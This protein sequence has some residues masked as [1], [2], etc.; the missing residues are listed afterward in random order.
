VGLVL[1]I[2]CANV[3]S[4]LLARA[5]SRQREIAIRLAI[6]ARRGR[7]IRQLLV[8]SALLS[9]V[10][11]AGGLVLAVFSGRV[12]LDML[13]TGAFHVDFDLTPNGHV[14]AFTTGVA[15]FTALL[16][17][18]AP[19]LQSTALN[20][21]ASLK[22]DARTATGISRWL[23]SLV[24]LQVALSLVLLIGAALFVGTLR[25][26]RNL[27]PG[28]RT[29]G[30]LLT[31]LDVPP[32]TPSV[33]L[34]EIRRVPGVASASFST[35]TP[36]SGARWSEPA[37]PAG[38]A[39]PDRD[40]ALFVGADPQFF[41]TLKIPLV[42][43]RAFVDR[44]AAGGPF[45]AIVNERYVQR[46]FAGK[47]PLG[48]HL[49]AR[50]NQVPRD[51]EIVGVARDTNAIGLRGAA[52][53]V[54][55]IPYV[56]VPRNRFATLTVRASG[57]LGDVAAAMRRILQPA[58]PNTPLQVRPLSAQVQATML[59]E[60]L[61]A[62]LAGTLGVLALVL[63]SVGIYGLLAYAVARRT[64]EIGV[65]MAL[66]AER[67]RVVTLILNDIRRPVMIGVLIGLPATW[68]ATRSVQSMLFGLQ[69][70]DPLA[71]GG[72][73]LILAAVAHAAAYLPARRAA[74]VD[75]LVAL[76]HE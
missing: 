59:Q 63:A 37:V 58:M 72:A 51:L 71:I 69:P 28:F 62:T 66:G 50:L 24:T 16:F 43:G 21:T 41:E 10:G 40:T 23:P 30:V 9:L 27:D 39:L 11:A 38:R 49:T 3:A 1:L 47:Y 53:A 13:S 46:F 45:V 42:S 22:E 44:D 32:A 67:R 60:R 2:A 25:N 8:E 36:L 12:L 15:M 6:G 74:R 57:G 20:P 75:P 5:S 73:I 18:L 4:L 65:R 7:I 61:M 14:L 76:R 56:Q 48:Q 17:G 35:H 68:A 26:L 31:E 29:E 54:V 34:D 55:Y 70:G 52:P 19:A 33:F 64:R